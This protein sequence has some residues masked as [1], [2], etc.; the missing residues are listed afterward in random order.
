MDTTVWYKSNYSPFEG[1]IMRC[2]HDT[3]LAQKTWRKSTWDF[4][5]QGSLSRNQRKRLSHHFPPLFSCCNMIYGDARVILLP[6]LRMAEQRERKNL[7]PWKHLGF[8]QSPKSEISHTCGL[9]LMWD[10]K[11]PFYQFHLGFLILIAK[12]ILTNVLIN[13]QE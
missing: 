8:A 13:E 2:T 6:T 7:I 9:S 10:S 3:I 4:K 12:G 5:K 11:I 1:L